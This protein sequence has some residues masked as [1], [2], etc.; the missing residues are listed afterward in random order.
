MPDHPENE[1][2]DPREEP[3]HG[4]VR[5]SQVSARVPDEVGD[6]CF[7]NG[8]MVLTG[9]FEIVLDFVNR[10][11]E[12]PRIVARVVLP[13]QVTS[14][15]VQALSQ[16]VANFE[17]RFGALP[18]PPQPNVPGSRSEPT[19]PNHPSDS[20]SPEPIHEG[21][22]TPFQGIAGEGFES[23]TPTS[24]AQPEVVSAS[25]GPPI[26]QIYDD[27][28]L[29][30]SMLSG[31]YA[32]AVLIR[33]SPTEFC[34]DFITNIYPRSAVSTRVYMAAANVHSLLT[35]LKRSLEQGGPQK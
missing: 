14:Q 12:A 33:H 8:V 2:R 23:G 20:L 16:N 7:S 9:P 31:R 11:S 28:R 15:F 22:E 1:P 4:Q 25:S 27:L 13:R 5:Y 29:P 35:S 32:N 3:I 19:P 26:D 24:P 30:D 17:S 18:R 10:L 6:G 21:I 34:L